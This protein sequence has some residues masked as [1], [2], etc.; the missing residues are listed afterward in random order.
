M[1]CCRLEIAIYIFIPYV[2]LFANLA[3]ML[4]PGFSGQECAMTTGAGIVES[5]TLSERGFES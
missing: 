2:S 3:L 4:W 5:V 1:I